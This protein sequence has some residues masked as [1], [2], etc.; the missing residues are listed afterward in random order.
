M[1]AINDL[2][3]SYQDNIVLKDFNLLLNSGDILSM[4]G[5]SGSGKSSVLRFI[6][7]LDNALS[8][9]VVLND[10]NLSANGKHII[11]TEKRNIGMVFQD[12]SLFPH[13][14]VAKN[15]GFG[16]LKYPKEYRIKQIKRLLN[17]IDLQNI[18]TKYPH[19]LSGGEQQRVALARSLAKK[20][21][22]LLL[23]EPFSNLD[24]KHKSKLITDVR[25]ILKQEKITSILVTH[26]KLEA[27]IFSD[28]VGVISNKKILISEHL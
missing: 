3:I 10:I 22:L 13:L 26:D 27:N 14:N 28:K 12:Y 17:L 8:G 23:D 9:S 5:D 25:N 19:Q 4:T 1:L 18:E 7:G 2:N 21:K 6:A 16:L 11:P 15:I 20:P 24:K